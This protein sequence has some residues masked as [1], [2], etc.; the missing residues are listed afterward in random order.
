MKKKFVSF[1]IVLMMVLS[2]GVLSACKSRYNKMEFVVEYAFK[3]ERGEIDQWYTAGQNLSLNFGNED[4][5]LDVTTNN[6]VFRVN[7]KNVKSK[8]IDDIVIFDSNSSS[9][10]IVKQNQEFK[11]DVQGA[12]QTSVRI[13]ETKSGKETSFR[14]NIFASLKDITTNV[15]FKPALAVGQSINLNLLTTANQSRSVLL[16]NPVGTNQT[17]VEYSIVGLGYYDG[18]NWVETANAAAA[19]DVVGLKNDVITITD[20]YDAY[21][22]PILKIKATSVFHKEQGEIS[23]LFDVYIIENLTSVNAPVISQNDELV[24]KKVLYV[25]D[26]TNQEY[27]TTVDVGIGTIVS[28]YINGVTLANGE[29]AR[30]GLNVYVDDI[31]VDIDSYD[32]YHGIRIQPLDNSG[33]EK[34]FVYEIT[35]DDKTYLTYPKNTIKFELTVL[36]LNYVVETPLYSANLEIEKRSVV[37]NVTLNGETS[38]TYPKGEIIATANSSV[39]QN[40]L[41]LTVDVLPNDGAVH[42]VLL[43][44]STGLSIT[45]RGISNIST[46]PN[47]NESVSGYTYYSVQNG[48][49]INV[50]FKTGGNTENQEIRLTT[51]VKGEDR[52]DAGYLADYVLPI[53]KV[54][55]ANRFEVLSSISGAEN[56]IGQTYLI[57]AEQET[58]FYLKVIYTGD[59]LALDTIDL[60]LPTTGDFAFK[61]GKTSINIK[62]DFASA[63]IMQVEGRRRLDSTSNEYYEIYQIPLKPINATGTATLTISAGKTGDYAL[64]EDSFA[65]KSV[66]VAQSEDFVM[67]TEGQNIATI[68]DLNSLNFDKF[69]IVNNSNIKSEIQFGQKSTTG[70][71]EQ[72]SVASVSLAKYGK[73]G[74][75]NFSSTAVEYL[76]IGRVDNANKFQIWGIQGGKT[77]RFVATITFYKR[78]GGIITEQQTTKE[79]EVAVYNNINSI[80]LGFGSSNGAKIVYINSN[81]PDAA[82]TTIT[83]NAKSALS[84]PSSS[85]SFGA[86]A[87]ETVETKSNINK[88]KVNIAGDSSCVE[89]YL[90]NN[91]VKT[92]LS[93]G[94]ILTNLT[95]NIVVKLIKKPEQSLNY[96]NLTFTAIS[97]DEGTAVSRSININF[98]KYVASSGIELEG[99]VL[100][101][102]DGVVTINMS[103][104]DVA[105]GGSAQAEFNAK[106]IYNQPVE[107]ASQYGDLDYQL[108]R[109]VTD[110]Q[111]NPVLNN[112]KYTT[113]EISKFANR[114]GVTINK[115]QNSVSLKADKDLGGGMFILRLVALDS[116]DE[117]TTVY[118][119]YVDL[120]VNITDGSS[121]ARYKIANAEDFAKIAN[122]LN[123]HYVLSKD[124]VVNNHTTFAGFS[125]S[126]S[127][128]DV[129]YTSSGNVV[130]TKRKLTITIAAPATE[131]ENVYYGI[132]EKLSGQAKI[133]DLILNVNFASISPRLTSTDKS[134]YIGGLAGIIEKN[135]QIENVEFNIN[136]TNINFNGKDSSGVTILS[137]D[138]YVGGVAGEMN[139]NINLTSC[140]VTVK[141]QMKSSFTTANKYIYFGGI[142]GKLGGQVGGSYK[143]P[144]DLE[145][146]N[147]NLGVNVSFEKVKGKEEFNTINLIAGGV[148]ATMENATVDGVVIM[149]QILVTDFTMASGS[150]AGVAGEVKCG[151]IQNVALLGV[152]LAANSSSLAVAGV[153]G[154]IVGTTEEKATIRNVKFIA[155][156][157]EDGIDNGLT[158]TSG[159]NYGLIY[160]ANNSSSVTGV[161][162]NVGSNATIT[163]C[164]VESF[165][166]K[167]YALLVGGQVYS[168]A[169]VVGAENVEISLSYVKANI[170]ATAENA[171]VSYLL[172][173]VDTTNCYYIG[174]FAGNNRNAG[175]GGTNNYIFVISADGN[176]AKYASYILE[177]TDIVLDNYSKDTANQIDTMPEGEW[178]LNATYNLVEVGDY[179]FYLPYLKDNFTLIPTDIT[180]SLNQEKINQIKSL[181]NNK[182]AADDDDFL[183][184]YDI[185]ETA[186]INYYNDVRNPLNNY[187]VDTY[188]ITDLVNLS[189]L[190][191][192]ANTIGTVV[193][194]VIRGANYASIVNGNQIYF[195]GVSGKDYIL[196]KAYSLFNPD[197]CDYFLFYTQT[198]FSNIE[199]EG[200]SVQVVDSVN[201]VYQLETYK[202]FEDVEI[203]VVTLNT[204][205]NSDTIYSS[206]FDVYNAK[207][208]VEISTTVVNLNGETSQH[209]VQVK[210]N[211]NLF[212]RL[213]ISSVKNVDFSN[214]E[215]Q[216]RITIVVR[217]NLTKYFG[218]TLYPQVDGLDQYETLSTLI[219]NVNISETATD[220]EF[221]TDSLE[222][223]SKESFAINATLHTGYVGNYTTENP[224]ENN[225][226]V[227]TRSNNDIVEFIEPDH[228]SLIMNFAV[229]S[230]QTEFERLLRQANVNTIPELFDID[231][232]NTFNATNKTYSYRIGLQL[233][234]SYNT[235]YLTSSIVFTIKIYAKT[236]PNI[237]GGTLIHLT[238]NPSSLSNSIVI[239]NYAASSAEAMGNYTHL[240]TSSQVETATITPGGNGGVLTIQMQPSYAYIGT[241]TLKSSELFVPS[242][243]NYVKA[244]FEQ[245]VY[246]TGLG[247]YIGIS[248]SCE[249]TEDG[250][251]VVLKLA[252]S[253][254]DGVNYTF[255]G[256]IYVHVVLDKKFSGLADEI[257]L[258][259]DVENTDG[260]HIVKTKSL[261]TDFLPG[262]ELAYDNEYKVVANNVEGYLIQQ[263]TT[264]NIVTLKIYGY[265]FNANPVV[266]IN[267]LDG[268]DDNNN[269][270]ADIDYQWLDK[271]SD[272]KPN[273]DG[274][275]T[276]RMAVAVR[277]KITKPF[278]V[279]VRMSL[280]TNN[281]I[282]T[283]SSDINFYPTDYILK[284]NAA[285]F[286]FGSK[287]NLAVNQSRDLTF[288]FATNNANLD[289]SAE[290]YLKL[291]ANMANTSV[292]EFKALPI[293]KKAEAAEKLLTN[294]AY[295]DGDANKTFADASEYFELY[296]TNYGSGS[297]NMVYLRLKANAKF[298]TSVKFKIFYSYIEQ[299]GHYVLTFGNEGT[300]YPHVLEI[301]F[302]MQFYTAT[303]RQQAFAISSAEQ[304]FDANGNCLLGEGQNYVLTDD[305]VVEL[306]KP[307]TTKIASLDGNNKK[308]IIKNFA[309]DS[310]SNS[311]E[312]AGYYGLFATVDTSTLLYN[313]VVDYSQFNTGKSGQ[314]VLAYENVTNVVF[315]GLAAVNNGL[316]YNCDVVNA[317]SAT[318]TINILLNNDASTEITFGGLVGINNGTITN[319]RV[320]RSE[321]TKIVANDN[322]QTSYTEFFK[323]LEFMIGNRT[324]DQGQGFKST[325]G[326]F[327]GVNNANKTISTSYVVNTGL[328]TYSTNIDSKLA[329]FVAENS[330]KISYSYVK[331]LE[332]S[333]TNDKPFAT[334]SKIEAYAD[335]NIA[336]FV[337][338]NNSGADINN[339]FA[340]T[341][342]V[343]KS[344]FMAGFVYINNNGARVAQCYAACTFANANSD[345]TLQITP[346]QP[347]VGADTTGLHSNGELEN[348]F[349]YKDTNLQNF[350]LFEDDNKPQATGLNAANFA[351]TTNLVNFVFVLSNSKND[352]DE[353]VWSFYNNQGNA[354]KLPELTIA[355][356]VA[357]SFRYES[358]NSSD[359][360][361]LNKYTYAT[362]FSLGSKNNPEIISSVQEFNDVFTSY[363]T[364]ST[365]TGYV[366]FIADIDFASDKAAIQTRR[367]FILGGE[368]N[369]ENAVAGS[370]TSIDGNG[371]YINNIYLDVGE[372]NEKSVG[373]FAEINRAYIKNLNLNFSS[374]DF[375]TANSVYSG[376]LAGRITDSVIVNISLDGASTT[377]QG[378]N[379]VGGLAGLIEGQSLVYGVSSNLSV[380][381]IMSGTTELYNSTKNANDSSY[382]NKVSYAGGIVGVADLSARAYSKEG[383]NLSFLYINENAVNK[384]QNLS[385][386]ADF[387]GG[388][389][390]YVGKNVKAMRL[391]FN[392]GNNNRIKGQYAAG[393]L[394][395]ASVGA[396]VE[397]SK[398]SALDTDDEQFAYDK[399]FADYVVNDLANLDSTAIGNTGLIESY[400]YGG[401]LIGVG[402]G[403][404]LFSCY[405]KASFYA[406][407]NVGGLIGLDVLSSLNFNYAVPYINFNDGNMEELKIVGGLIGVAEDA[408]SAS[409]GQAFTALNKNAGS[410]SYSFSTILLDKAAYA[411]YVE[412]MDADGI[413]IENQKFNCFVGSDFADHVVF[414]AYAGNINYVD[415]PVDSTFTTGVVIKEMKSLYDLETPDS[416]L[417][418]FNA[419]FSIWDTK[420]WNL[421]T[422]KHFFPLL[423]DQRDEN[424]ELITDAN[425]FEKIRNNPSGS[426]KIVNDIDM[427]TYKGG[428]NFVFDFMFEGVLVGEKSNGET[429]IVYNLQ[430]AA[431]NENDDAG[432]FRATQGARLRNIEFS[433]KEQGV[434]TRNG[435]IHNFAGLSATDTASSQSKEYTQISAVSVTVGRTPSS[436]ITDTKELFA[437]GMSITGFAGLI[438]SATGTNLL[439]CA[440]S[441]QVTANV[442]STSTD[443]PRQLAG[444]IG[445]GSTTTVEDEVYTLSIVNSSVGDNQQTNF[446]FT[447]KETTQQVNFGV[448]AAELNQTAA[449]GNIVGS[450][451]G[452]TSSRRTVSVEIYLEG[453]SKDVR[454]AG[455]VAMAE[456][457]TIESNTS[458]CDIS[459]KDKDDAKANKETNLYLA[460]LISTYMLD[461]PG[462]TLSFNKA[463]VNIT[464]TAAVDC[465]FAAI[466]VAYSDTENQVEIIQ[467][468]LQGSISVYGN[469]V[470]GAVVA[471]AYGGD[472]N[473]AAQIKLDQVVANVNITPT[474]TKVSE[475]NNNAKF[476]AD[477]GGLVGNIDGQLTLSNTMNMGKIIPISKSGNVEYNIGGVAGKVST[478]VIDLNS[479]SFDLSSI[480]VNDLV[481]EALA[482]RTIQD[483]KGNQTDEI[484]N[485]GALVGQV[486]EIKIGNQSYDTNAD[487]L[488]LQAD[489]F[490]STDLSLVPEDTGLGTN[491]TYTTLLGADSGYQTRAIESGL[492]VNTANPNSNIPY[493]A[494]L[495]TTLRQFNILQN[496]SNNYVSG[497]AANPKTAYVKTDVSYYYLLG[498]VN[499]ESQFNGIVIGTPTTE[500]VT[501]YVEEINHG[502]AIS[503]FHVEYTAN[504]AIEKSLVEVNNGLIFNCSI[505]GTISGVAS[506]LGLI[507]NQNNGTISHCFNS[508]EIISQNEV[509]AMAL[510][511]A[512]TISSSYFTGNMVLTGSGV[513]R[514]MSR[515]GGYIYNCYS[516]GNISNIAITSFGS[517]VNNGYNNFVDLLA[518]PKDG[519]NVLSTGDNLALKGVTTYQLM[520]A[521][522][523]KGSWLSAISNKKFDLKNPLFGYNFNYPI[524]NFNQYTTNSANA[525]EK[526]A[527]ATYSRAT[528]DGF[529]NTFEVPHLGVLSSIQGVIANNGS[530]DSSGANRNYM[531]THDI[532]GLISDADNNKLCVDWYAVG[533]NDDGANKF[534]ASSSGF[535]G[536]FD[537]AKTLENGVVTECYTIS[538]LA[539]NGLFTNVGYIDSSLGINAQ[540]KISNIKFAGDFVKMNNSGALGVSV[541]TG[542]VTVENIDISGLTVYAINLEKGN[543]VSML[544]SEQN[545]GEL[546][547][548][549]LITETINVIDGE[550][551][552][553]KSK[554]E[555]NGKGAYGAILAVMIGGKLKFENVQELFII[556]E[557]DN[558]SDTDE[559]TVGGI[560]GVASKEKVSLSGDTNYGT[561]I[562]IY[563]TNHKTAGGII[564]SSNG[565]SIEAYKFNIV[566]LNTGF[567]VTKFG[568]FIGSLTE[569]TAEFKNCVLKQTDFTI[570]FIQGDNRY[571]GLIAGTVENAGLTVDEFAYNKIIT[572]A[573]SLSESAGKEGTQGFGGFVGNMSQS[574]DDNPNKSSL[575]IGSTGDFKPTIILLDGFNLGGL[576]GSYGGGIIDLPKPG[577]IKL[578]GMKN[579][580]GAIGYADAELQ[581]SN[582][583]KS[584][585]NPNQVSN[586]NQFK[587][588]E[589]NSSL[590]TTKINGENWGGL[591]GKATENCKLEGLS[592]CNSI[593]INSSINGNTLMNVGGIVGLTN[594]QIVK[595]IN[596]ANITICD[597]SGSTESNAVS[598]N[599][600][601]LF[602]KSNNTEMGSANVSIRPVNVG[603]IAGKAEGVNAIIEGCILG[604]RDEQVIIQGYESVGGIVGSSSNII[605]NF[606]AVDTN[607]TY[608]Q[609]GE[610]YYIYDNQNDSYSIANTL[611]AGSDA[612][613]NDLDKFEQNVD[614][615]VQSGIIQGKIMGAYNVGGVVGKLTSQADS[616]TATGKVVGVKTQADVYGNTNVGGLVG[617]AAANTSVM[618]NTVAQKVSYTEAGEPTGI[619]TTI[620]GILV[621]DYVEINGTQKSYYFIP[622]SV[623]GLIGSTQIDATV[624]TRV[625]NNIV[626]ADITSTEEGYTPNQ[627]TDGNS[628]IEGENQGG[629][630]IS[631]ISNYMLNANSSSLPIDDLTDKSF[632]NKKAFNNITTG[633]GGLIGTTDSNTLLLTTKEV[634][635][636]LD[637]FAISKNKI[638]TNI[639]ARLG[640]NVGTYYGGL[641]INKAISIG[642]GESSKQIT[643]VL[644]SLQK[645]SS[646]SGAYNIGGAIGYAAITSQTISGIDYE[647]SPT[648]T[649]E[650]QKEGVGM[651]VG[652]VF[653]KFKGNVATMVKNAD[654]E[655]TSTSA[656]I[657]LGSNNIKIYTAES[658][659][660]GGLVGRLEGNMY[661]S[662]VTVA[663]N[664]NTSRLNVEGSSVQ[665]FGGLV[666]MLKVPADAKKVEGGADIYVNGKQPYAFTI[667][668]IENQNYADGESVLNA[669]KNDD[670][671]IE[672]YAQAYYIN[673]DRF[674]ISSSLNVPEKSPLNDTA[675]WHKD[676]TGFR[677][678]QRCIPASENKQDY[679]NSNGQKVTVQAEWD[680]VSIVYDAG[681]IVGVGIVTET[682]D[683]VTTSRI[684]Y[685]IYEEEPD[686]PKLYTKFG[687]GI[688][689]KDKNGELVDANTSG[690]KKVIVPGAQREQTFKHLSDLDNPTIDRGD[691]QN[692]TVPNYG[693]T[694]SYTNLYYYILKYKNEK[695]AFR[696]AIIYDKDS[697]S[698]S[699][700]VLEVTGLATVSSRQLPKVNDKII[701]SII[702]GIVA[703]IGV[704]IG[705]V[706]LFIPG[707][708]FV[709]ACIAVAAIGAGAGGLVVNV[710]QLIRL[711]KLKAQSDMSNSFYIYHM[712]QNMGY[713]SSLNSREITYQR[714]AD[715]EIENV[716]NSGYTYYDESIEKYYVKYSTVRPTSYYQEL[717][718]KIELDSNQAS[719]V[720]GSIK[721]IGNIS[722]SENVKIVS[723]KEFKNSGAVYNS[724]AAYASVSR[725][726]GGC[727]VYFFNFLY[728]DGYY[729]KCTISGEM[730]YNTPHV[731]LFE[732]LYEDDKL[733]TEPRVYTDG[734]MM[735]VY[736]SYK[737]LNNE[738]LDKTYMWDDSNPSYG[739]HLKYANGEYSLE[740]TS[741]K[742]DET[743][744]GEGIN[745]V[746]KVTQK[747]VYHPGYTTENLVNGYDYVQ[748]VYLTYKGQDMP[749]YENKYATFVKSAN[750]NVAGLKENIDYVKVKYN[751]KEYTKYTG[752]NLVAGETY[753]RLENGAYN[754][755]V[756]TGVWPTDGQNNRIDVY[757]QTIAYKTSIYLIGAVSTDKNNNLP[758][759]TTLET[760]YDN[761][762][763]VPTSIQLVI[764]PY[765]FTNPYSTVNV[766]NTNSQIS[767]AAKDEYSLFINS[768]TDST[769][770]D[771]E[772]ISVEVP[773]Y[774]WQGGFITGSITVGSGESSNTVQNV[775][776][777]MLD[778]EQVE[779]EDNVISVPKSSAG[780]VNLTA[781]QLKE[782]WNSYVNYKYFDGKQFSNVSD[783]FEYDSKTNK[784][785]MKGSTTA[786]TD[787]TAILLLKDEKAIE[788]IK[789]AD[790]L[791]NYD[792]HKDKTELMTGYKVGDIFKVA[793]GNLYMIKSGT[794]TLGADNQQAGLLYEMSFK[795]ADEGVVDYNYNMY[796]S[797][798]EFKLYTRYKY[799]Y[800]YESKKGKD[801]TDIGEY[802]WHIYDG[803]IDKKMTAK[804]TPSSLGSITL[805]NGIRT[806]FVERVMVSLSCG[807]NNNVLAKIKGI[808]NSLKNNKDY[809]SYIGKITIS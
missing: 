75:V 22:N 668:T 679:L 86:G 648:K 223:E 770:A 107:S 753:Y 365:F 270:L 566:L 374:G 780:A 779:D 378:A 355:N 328:Y 766:Y 800:K 449:S 256:T 5:K 118:N 573:P 279:S 707:L 305:I 165:A 424:Y 381:A 339:C 346:E 764:K 739:N 213:T 272:L 39:S 435:S 353:G 590:S 135:V 682:T 403:S 147:Y 200:G 497:S 260:T 330:G 105:D 464:S 164:S 582:N 521:S 125:G 752:D 48:T 740:G 649:I 461:K 361:G 787:S 35:A 527:I 171:D 237:D 304:M 38:A 293:A 64:F 694:K 84:T 541:S 447:L 45:G 176:S 255:D 139:G 809:Q 700:S 413:S 410:T 494:S 65:V 264:N 554:L 138:V 459:V 795:M 594:G 402:V 417:A 21:V 505:T 667:N 744:P 8:Y 589:I 74:D 508:A 181:Y 209:A 291:L 183:K 275:Y 584:F 258:T 411:N 760:V 614:Y 284:L 548:N 544:F 491:L 545:G 592:N 73:D 112:G 274:S 661:N 774:I 341:E 512:G 99:D 191:N 437:E 198:W 657:T 231:V 215:I 539:N 581:I 556:M 390:G 32:D 790:L 613:Y 320:G 267:W 781:K 542:S 234:D 452:E 340:N 720:V 502:A 710:T 30:Y 15:D 612:E 393:G 106:A 345:T 525:V 312:T 79:F 130:E 92:E 415:V 240:I 129:R 684:I 143:T 471:K 280:V 266:N 729:W 678:M 575:K 391:S 587:F 43:A 243:N 185:T 598:E 560:I 358:G 360:T 244:R 316:I 366:R 194:K 486:N 19:A 629:N 76:T 10:Q 157:L 308:I 311:S 604:D 40:G 57:D 239:N 674:N 430:V 635:Q 228:D 473:K 623:G 111:G 149:G 550:E 654:G 152:N 133:S 507:A 208:F 572:I 489:I 559:S 585:L 456:S 52:P 600:Y 250:L 660:I 44:V 246:H 446:K 496:S 717:Y 793:D 733:A 658:Y 708:Q 212:N 98:G 445:V 276:M 788:Q 298:E 362:K 756:S 61:N 646:I 349:W 53:E 89:V 97:F 7:V 709:P 563:F 396:S 704:I 24:A 281:E 140:P 570:N 732:K 460:G 597:N 426:F 81:Y 726:D 309:V 377:I 392:I 218:S 620:K 344:A 465:T 476:T 95:G 483:E 503:N 400:Q 677:A 283:E 247:K 532:N 451:A 522:L 141:G 775:I 306:A 229:V 342:L 608:P 170:S 150:V 371:M 567:T 131:T 297:D 555:P 422:Y 389:A 37:K 723:Q 616:S 206:L 786:I 432:L 268:E 14:L 504:T 62:N 509:S 425:S 602:V 441:G 398:V 778:N 60:S 222:G 806:Y 568:G 245:L 725:D 718:C 622:T 683:G 17:A 641:A 85:I 591:I 207:E 196:V 805:N 67:Q 742:Y 632:F 332:S 83:Y 433:W 46:Y 23:T 420:Y 643:I 619:N 299:D 357:H 58:S 468:V 651:Y 154:S 56:Y 343:S 665:N 216:E 697:Y 440:F 757:Y 301:A 552:I 763:E 743:K 248:P 652:G 580:G 394:F 68:T 13:Y 804:V 577:I 303:T 719:D 529:Y 596:Y 77:T 453:V 115:A 251:G 168:L 524:Y 226:F 773:Y 4:D 186:I 187:S 797:N 769:L 28:Q 325:I 784:L 630:V 375:S 528:G 190:P 399:E 695:T 114:L 127:G 802:L 659:F 31:L 315:G 197:A 108:F 543:N 640:I 252:S 558:G 282:K 601:N 193:Y 681:N 676:Y 26:D 93:N 428:T 669:T 768:K 480:L 481:G 397:A 159:T 621:H 347:F 655:E 454:V 162:A 755:F 730:T 583:T 671:D 202:D 384:N 369:N 87:G 727:D 128:K 166:D 336:G 160:N 286:E 712:Q 370:Y 664:N 27:K 439:N 265:Q 715:G 444:L 91:G 356:N 606:E 429:P 418:T 326:G 520:T 724:E 666:G 137:T 103:F 593:Q 762:N 319:S 261:V 634:A 307:I 364:V 82:T 510:I 199:L 113:V 348:C 546:I 547:I 335:G 327:V 653:G 595:C 271:Y 352:R 100:T 20:N 586:E 41:N 450:L 531:L 701:K 9:N 549:N 551:K 500:N 670:G 642:E 249:Q 540:T 479:Y 169:N 798:A 288:S 672:L 205:T 416:Q 34:V 487:K 475:S 233:K 631:T 134:V 179:T 409:F 737:K 2:C 662:S 685:T 211:G 224:A 749:Q 438:Y 431:T 771:G 383:Y 636:S 285:K 472:E 466:G 47:L 16:F 184:D 59:N 33:K 741:I 751:L 699:G 609:S 232:F 722:N 292:E 639:N 338:E 791:K 395:A 736:G 96:I 519:A 66:F 323:P 492:W 434:G 230:G 758:D 482:K 414:Q 467:T 177:E 807:S 637:D 142:A 337:Y 731:A 376:G 263:N 644:P 735:Y 618:N 94:S 462:R 576:I 463:E 419:I 153:A 686:S 457:C 747:F 257:R 50:N 314:L 738:D 174:R 748:G 499:I 716:S 204:K 241:T 173:N 145:G 172:A 706:C 296:T 236:N 178:L 530:G 603:G 485:I 493:L 650:V 385:I 680:S 703:G 146:F 386:V 515:A 333:I 610:I 368:R 746:Y 117:L 401:G 767:K 163:L 794:Y 11:L 155:F 484:K 803:I 317:G 405:S 132:F 423:T 119:N 714:N 51:L 645:D 294:F 380:S 516:A 421:D 219:V 501:V 102:E 373:L 25:N 617:Y 6:L 88:I 713:L 535:T 693:D 63:G 605:N 477:V 506:D 363:G 698:A 122:N 254:N 351:D 745:P 569:G 148:A 469:S 253:T 534:A 78:D 785:T 470:I 789:Y 238:I 188:T 372:D 615:F 220:L 269:K 696:F 750:D 687:V 538:N 474:L 278:K 331:G 562:N 412:E 382:A 638:T 448:L 42:N 574:N 158:F 565:A 321:F 721:E 647:Y 69:A 144:K 334:G 273:A 126:I 690:V 116:F 367:G 136:V 404:T 656:G 536:N 227:E 80:E 628:S 1:L 561:N 427:S 553:S 692:A 478:I 71:F 458:Y 124:I 627:E 765:S 513:G 322:S 564:G 599:F 324:L 455:L 379:M 55:T 517:G 514:A 18:V 782:N 526:M 783:V 675:G 728:I 495:Y 523:L 318:K 123:A 663:E 287:L 673:L 518:T 242:L 109:I 101:K 313:V 688:L 49:T 436:K 182:I 302:D 259:L 777:A 633:F 72:K 225:K 754:S 189:I 29:V 407:V 277:E 761:E 571:F 498:S 192:D 201:K 120:F 90:N 578:Q 388:V 705:V 210:P 36:G 235:R 772:G 12:Q 776:Y 557:E 121:T 511:N 300:T 442:V 161:A 359:E 3:D 290:I 156:K 796:L 175:I 537:G 579:V 167:T 711:Y 689:F 533:Y 406:G 221:N 350:I 624:G 626:F 387:A 151:T 443:Q 759:S 702:S 801:G 625:E 408:S 611:K 195:K 214:K 354:V 295:V 329:G 588:A 203:D 808:G 488:T 310:N 180:G 70:S 607:N 217:L 792:D 289:S 734:T 54:V 104:I 799:N 110:E 490:Y 691:R 262:V